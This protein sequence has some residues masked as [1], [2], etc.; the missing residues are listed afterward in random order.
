M[1]EP[2]CVSIVDPIHAAS[3][4]HG[5]AAIGPCANFDLCQSASRSRNC[6]GK[7]ETGI[8]A[9]RGADC[10]FLNLLVV[11]QNLQENIAPLGRGGE[12]G[13]D[14]GLIAAWRQRQVGSEKDA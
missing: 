13:A 11:K 5:S 10:L 7:E 1:S 14:L 6:E 8:R 12:F 9:L 2:A 3:V 4:E